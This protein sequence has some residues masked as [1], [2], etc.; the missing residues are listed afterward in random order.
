MAC[1]A[2]WSLG[3]L[4]RKQALGALRA[5]MAGPPSALVPAWLLLCGIFGE[6]QDAAT[7]LSL[8]GEVTAMAAA[9]RAVGELG[10][11][12]S[13]GPL[14]ERLSSG[15]PEVALAA[16]AA[17]ERMLGPLTTLMP[18]VQDEAAETPPRPDSAA[19]ASEVKERRSKLSGAATYL[20]GR[21]YPWTDAPREEPLAWLWRGNV[22]GERSDLGWMRREVPDGVLMGE[23][24]MDA[25][26]GE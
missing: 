26:V 5:H 3:L 15:A 16:A 19:V 17:L 2:L 24:A 21:P 9:T 22:R 8:A 10:D 20:D 14:L 6:R 25:R 7:L 4:D 18:S 1:G 13:V 23:W 12:D 11:L